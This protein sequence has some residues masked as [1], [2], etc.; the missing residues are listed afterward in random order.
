MWSC[1]R[2]GVFRAAGALA[3]AAVV[4]GCQ[5]AASAGRST[6]TSRALVT[7]TSAPAATTTRVTSPPRSSRPIRSPRLDDGSLGSQATRLACSLLSR[8]EIQGQFGGPVSSA[9]PTYPYCQWRVGNDAFLAL[10]VEQ[11][12]SFQ[13]AT[14][15]VQTLEVLSGLG[16]EAIIANNR[17]LYFTASGTTYWLLWQKV[18]DFSLLHTHQLVTLARDVLARAQVNRTTRE[19]A[20]GPPGPPIYFAGDS[21]AAGPEWAWDTYFATSPDLKTLSEY[22]VGTGLVSPDFFDWQRHLLGVVAALRPRL[23]IY[24]GSANDGQDLFVANSF[25]PVGSRLWRKA[26]ADRVAGI[27]TVLAV[28]GPEC[29]GSASQQCRTR[30]CRATWR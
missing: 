15:Y 11:R 26:Y 29:S 22:Q 18:G 19:P 8:G 9:T 21:T 14:Q 16:R 3:V 2:K 17:Y 28:K 25:Q 1:A 10:A 7:T 23:V 24:M 6:T 4:G 30:S 13:T 27:M 12:T 20:L 5:P